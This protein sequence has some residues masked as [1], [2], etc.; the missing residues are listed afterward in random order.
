MINSLIILFI[1]LSASLISF[2][3]LL[4]PYSLQSWPVIFLSGL[5]A[6]L[7]AWRRAGSLPRLA[8]RI[9]FL[10]AL[11]SLVA[12]GFTQVLAANDLPSGLLPLHALPERTL[13]FL[14]LGGMAAIGLT[15]LALKEAEGAESLA[16][17]VAAAVYGS[18]VFF[19]VSAVPEV[20]YAFGVLAGFGA[21]A[22]MAMNNS[23]VYLAPGEKTFWKWAAV[24]A[25]AQV[26]AATISPVP[27]Q[28]LIYVTYALVL[29]GLAALVAQQIRTQQALSG[30]A[31]LVV[32]LG[33]GIP[34]VLA[35]IKAMDIWLGFGPAAAIT[36]RLHPSEMGGANLLAHSLLVAAPFGVSLIFTG[37]AEGRR[38]NIR[39]VGLVLLQIA[40]LVVILYARSFEGF[41]AWLVALAVYGLLAGWPRLQAAWS[42]VARRPMFRVAVLGMV[43][44]IIASVIFIGFRAGFSMNPYSFNGRIGHW[45]GA[46]SAFKNH[47]LL[48]GGQDNEYLYTQF[49]S[50]VSLFSDVP[51]FMDDPLYVIRYRWGILTV[52]AHN[53]ILETAAFSGLA[54]LISAGGMLLALGWYGV[55]A[56]R[57][58]E[59]DVRI[60][61]AACLA[62]MLGELAWGAL[63]VIRESPPFFTF[64]V[65]ALV[66]MTLAAGRITAAR[67]PEP[68]AMTR[69]NLDRVRPAGALVIAILLVLVP[70]LASNQYSSGFLA[71]QEHRWQAAARHF[72]T[73]SQVNPLS[74]QYY[75]MLSKAELELEQ[76]DEAAQ[77]LEKAISLKRGYS[78]YLSQAGWLAW[79]NGDLETAERYFTEAIA[80]D[81]LES[82]TP[83]LNANMGFLR[84]YQRR[85]AEAIGLVAK[86]LEYH[87]EL[88]LKA[89]W[90][91][92][93]TPEHGIQV[94]LAPAFQSGRLS[95]DLQNRIQAHLG[96][97]NLTAHNFEQPLD[98]DSY[99]SLSQVFDALHNQYIT[100]VTQSNPDAHLT[101]AAEAEAARQVGLSARAERVYREYQSLHPKSAFGYRDLGLSYAEQG[102]LQEA[103]IWLKKAVEVSPKNIDSL[104]LLTTIQGNLGKTIDAEDTF[105]RLMQIASSNSFQFQFFDFDLI[106]AMGKLANELNNV[107]LELQAQDW[108]AKIQATPD[109][110]LTL[111][112]LAQRAGKHD[113]TLKSCWKAYQSL[114]RNWVR[115][116]DGRLW[117][118][119]TCI[120][121][122]DLTNSQ[123]NES[124][125]R[126][127]AGFTSSL[128]QGHVARLRNQPDLSVKYYQQAAAARPDESASYYYL[129][130]LYSSNGHA[131][132]AEQE[133]QRAVELDNCESL[134]ALALGRLYENTGKFDEALLAYKTAVER[135]PSWD[136]AQIALGNFYLKSGNFSQADPHFK[137]ARQI[138]GGFDPGYK[139]DFASSL[140]NAK[141]SENVAD[142]YI[143]TGIYEID[144]VRK[145]SI[146]MHPVSSASYPL[147]MPDIPAGSILQ[148]EFSLGMLPDSW[149]QAGD[150]VNFAVDLR[151]TSQTVE[152]Y[153]AY[154]DPKHNPQDRL[155][156]QAQVDLSAYAG[157]KVTLTLRTDGGEAGDLQFDWACWGEPVLAI[158]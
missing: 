28:S 97:A 150:G 63:D 19:R 26:A 24:F 143:K 7:L 148:L 135:T 101:L 45:I 23:P 60:I 9:P 98:V 82:W 27:N 38:R 100:Q 1:F 156:H 17:L 144:G 149:S 106:E 69:L 21:L 79:L 62:G 119:A 121:Q 99:L 89:D 81:P 3:D 34:V 125:K 138:S 111:A 39:I 93:P 29:L 113:L 35:V 4:T 40:I 31:W 153:S 90:V 151:T 48:G 136:E 92:L 104:R 146:F 5:I 120:A 57:R 124:M 141:F 49:A 157:Q 83:G 76:F 105:T 68:L 10:L 147:T 61:L 127:P 41:F 158:R 152:I 131:E 110:Y 107:E 51:Q 115:P 6:A 8:G 86:S 33:A 42:R 108:L 44:L 139:V 134:A 65:W 87:P 117:N 67:Q 75:W 25:L 80:A 114:I 72:Q 84:S 133:Y 74:A 22:F 50:G 52:H 88:V 137:L 118:T 15:W 54:G 12:V 46:L 53:L 20:G 123:F 43:G 140:A 71:F 73:A 126:Y 155:W 47:L 130:E 96:M 13:I 116:Y 102:R 85:Q 14:I 18:V 66:G 78:P 94:I 64:P 30:A 132:K 129:G 154:I 128:F 122:S 16:A 2:S 145:F 109:R 91:K 32:L 142:G 112:S 77:H 95:A 36:Y 37:Q 103:E 56:W 11:L 55:R 59:Q 70:A 58:A